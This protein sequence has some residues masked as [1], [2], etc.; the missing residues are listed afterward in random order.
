ME[1]AQSVSLSL[2]SLSSTGYDPITDEDLLTQVRELL[3]QA[4]AWD[5]ET[6]VD[7]GV[8]DVA[9]SCCTVSFLNGND[10]SAFYLYVG[11][12]GDYV[13]ARLDDSTAG[14]EPLAVLPEGTLFQLE[15][16]FKTQLGRN[17]STTRVEYPE[18]KNQL[19][20]LFLGVEECVL[21]NDTED[22]QMEEWLTQYTSSYE[23]IHGVPWWLKDA[24]EGW[25]AQAMDAG[26]W[27]SIIIP[28]S[29]VSQV[30]A[31]CQEQAQYPSFDTV[32]SALENTDTIQYAAM[33]A[34]SS[35][36]I[37]RD[38]A[39]IDQITQLILTPQDDAAQVSDPGRVTMGEEL[40]VLTI[41]LDQEHQLFLC[42]QEVEGGCLLSCGR[43]D[44]TWSDTQPVLWTLPAGT[45]HKIYA[46]YEDWLGDL[47]Q[48]AGAIAYDWQ[49]SLSFQALEP[50]DETSHPAIFFADDGTSFTYH[51][52]YAW[53]GLT[54][55]LGMR[56]L[57]GTKEYSQRVVGG[58]LEG[59]IPDIPAGSY[60]VFV[61]N[62]SGDDTTPPATLGPDGRN[63]SGILLFLRESSPS[64]PQSAQADGTS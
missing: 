21:L 6:S 17:Q 16:L 49:D 27:Y 15:D 46:I 2:P 39:V 55:E 62:I 63:A 24:P 45:A 58:D 11:Q 35:R 29:I 36:G 51:I 38:P 60:Q 20:Q 10:T 50:G 3:G 23:I 41:P 57:D 43:T 61:R 31:I 32:Y 37:I 48:S 33:S 9:S 8:Q 56:S 52:T 18:F 34:M 12:G 22:H 1:D 26:S 19:T 4:E 5:Q 7:L 40:G 28:D 25:Y 42:L 54:L 30:Q 13:L 53:T 14:A 44:N 59:T 64:S 47:N